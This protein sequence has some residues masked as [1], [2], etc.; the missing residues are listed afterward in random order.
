V[1]LCLRGPSAFFVLQILQILSGWEKKRSKLPLLQAESLSAYEGRTYYFIGDEMPTHVASKVGCKHDALFVNRL[2]FSLGA[3]SSA[4]VKKSSGG[5]SISSVYALIL[6]LSGGQ[7]YARYMLRA[8]LGS[9]ICSRART[10]G[11]DSICSAYTD[12]APVT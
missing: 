3:C 12:E 9:K 10:P 7:A 1:S 8:Q 2:I 6:G 5:V 4:G 11:T